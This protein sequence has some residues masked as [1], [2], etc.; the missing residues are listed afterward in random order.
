MIPIGIS[1]SA[2]VLVGNC[3]GRK[4]VIDGKTFAKM[5]SIISIIW[6]CLGSLV[7]YFFMQPIVETYS[8]DPIV[9]QI[10]YGVFLY[11]IYYTWIDCLQGVCQGLISGIGRQGL[12]SLFAIFGFWGLGI[13]TCL[14]LVFWY[15]GSI[16]ALWIGP[17]VALTFIVASQYAVIYGSDWKKI[18]KE[19]E[20]RRLKEKKQY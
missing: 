12:A 4:D 16:E 13:P 1:Q 8:T 17:S 15:N 6:A 3:I 11:V 5:C 7:M 19:A 2:G 18:I 20:K 10:I 9:N 14:V